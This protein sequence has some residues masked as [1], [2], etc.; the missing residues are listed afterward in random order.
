MKLKTI[1]FAAL[2]AFTI[3]ASLAT[4]Q[5]IEF[6]DLR[7]EYLANPHGLRKALPTLGKFQI[8]KFTIGKSSA[9][10]TDTTP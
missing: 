3:A 9:T 10:I 4:A 1:L 5:A 8:G 7:C 6:T 2:A